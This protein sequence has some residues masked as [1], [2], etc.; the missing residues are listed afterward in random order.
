MAFM[1]LAFAQI[2]H[3]GNARATGDVLHPTRMMANPVALGALVVALAL[4]TIPA[5]WPALGTVL[6]VTR[7]APEGWL[8]V[9]GLA[10]IPAVLGQ[11]LK[12][13]R[14]IRSAGGGRGTGSD[15][16][17]AHRSFIRGRA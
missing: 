13:H 12:L 5:I 8:L 2:F 7:L 16:G 15:S 14:R 9:L 1:T 11:T 10:A 17:L 6:A 3:L 4:Q